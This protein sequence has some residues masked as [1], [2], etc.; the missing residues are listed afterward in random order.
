MQQLATEDQNSTAP[1]SGRGGKRPGAGR[2]KG[3]SDYPKTTERNDAFL[4]YAKAKAQ[5]EAYAAKKAELEVKQMQ[6]ELIAVADVMVVV[7]QAGRACKEHLLGIAGR[8]GDVFAAESDGRAIERMIDAEIRAA[9]Q[10][11]VDVKLNG[12]PR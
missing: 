2:P 10:H 3:A 9:L 6:G 1:R 4:L 5:K 11:I 12:A 8:F 7:D